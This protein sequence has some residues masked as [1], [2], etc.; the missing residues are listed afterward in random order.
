MEAMCLPTG[1]LFKVTRVQVGDSSDCVAVSVTVQSKVRPEMYLIA[2]SRCFSESHNLSRLSCLSQNG[3]LVEP[4]WSPALP[5]PRTRTRSLSRLC[6]RLE[7][8]VSRVRPAAG[9]PGCESCLHPRFGRP[10]PECRGAHSRLHCPLQ[11]TRD[12][13]QLKPISVFSEPARFPLYGHREDCLQL[14]RTLKSN[15]HSSFINITYCYR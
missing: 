7:F 5:R 14:H 4:K 10:G 3:F 2:V 13:Q 11:G 12:R 9:Q 1:E 15:L 8:A 6:S